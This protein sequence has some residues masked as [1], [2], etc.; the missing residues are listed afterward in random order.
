SD[1]AEDHVRL[2][3]VG[4]AGAAQGVQHRLD[5][6]GE[7]QAVPRV[8]HRRVPH[9]HVADV[10]EVRVL[11]EL[12][13]DALEGF[14][15][16]H[17]LQGELEPL[18]VI[19]EGAEVGPRADGGAHVFGGLEPELQALG[20]GEVHDRLWTQGAVQVH[21]EIGLR[22]LVEDLEGDVLRPFGGAKVIILRYHRY[23]LAQPPPLS[24][25]RV[26]ALFRG[27][28]RE[29]C[30]R[31][32][33]LARRWSLAPL[34]PWHRWFPG[35]AGSLA[36]R[37]PRSRRGAAFELLRRAVEA[38]AGG[39]GASLLTSQLLGIPGEL[40][41][42][43]A[44]ERDHG[45]EAGQHVGPARHAEQVVAPSRAIEG[46]TEDLGALRA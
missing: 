37:R 24:L 20:A 30:F 36:P 28:F 15:L 10:L 35:T 1:A 41:P 18:E 27:P 32:C 22:E 3:A 46:V 25:R 17:D 45:H 13:G 6:G 38:R 11:G 40:V 23:K 8:Q 5:D 2:D 4:L 39:A 31:G 19:D 21:V 42:A 7:L 9:L 43:D 44:H 34:V 14:L 12:E 16:L 26:S 29:A 33:M